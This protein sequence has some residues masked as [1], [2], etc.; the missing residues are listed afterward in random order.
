MELDKGKNQKY[1]SHHRGNPADNIFIAGGSYQYGKGSIALDTQ[2]RIEH[3]GKKQCVDNHAEMRDIAEKGEKIRV[4]QQAFDKVLNDGIRNNK[5]KSDKQNQWNA[6]NKSYDNVATKI[7][8]NFFIGKSAKKI[9]K[10]TE[11]AMKALKEP[12]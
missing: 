3:S 7:S 12:L 2:Q 11:A 9:T 5:E 10:W 6:N 1:Y 8:F 4:I